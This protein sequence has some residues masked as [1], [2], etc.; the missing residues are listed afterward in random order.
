MRINK[1]RIG[2]IHVAI[3]CPATRERARRDVFKSR[4]VHTVDPVKATP[5][6][7]TYHRN[8]MT[9][10]SMDSHTECDANKKVAAA[11]ERNQH[12]IVQVVKAHLKPS[13]SK[14][15]IVEVASGTGQHAAALGKAFQ[16]E[17]CI[18][19]PSDMVTEDFESIRA[20]SSGLDNVLDPIRID[21]SQDFTTWNI[22]ETS[23]D[24]IICIN[25]AHI[26]P[27]QATQG[28]CRGAALALKPGGLLFIYGP[29]LVNGKPTT[30]SNSAFDA[31]L[32]SRN[33]EWGLRDVDD[34]IDAWCQSHGLERHH[35][36]DMPANNAML[37][38]FKK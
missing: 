10:R 11:A 3:L 16:S 14:R 15:F 17:N 9:L 19:Q 38:Y 6:R 4:H 1:S 35:V 2:T 7:T 8:N 28:L 26:S 18:I 33:P 30:P 12:V 37:I 31:S 27:K 32:K 23:C 22:A 36:L 24:A 5:L 34:D 25:M 21:C 13:T 29:F 20:W